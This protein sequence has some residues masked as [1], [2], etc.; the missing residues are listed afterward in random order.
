[1]KS[2]LSFVT[3][4]LH[5]LKANM[6]LQYVTGIFYM[7]SDLTLYLFKPKHHMSKLMKK[8]SKDHII[9]MLKRKFE[10]LVM[11]Y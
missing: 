4:L 8:P 5:L 11:F 1:M 10:V 6:N 7:L 2:I 3:R 9:K